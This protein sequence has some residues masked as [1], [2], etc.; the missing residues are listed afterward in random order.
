MGL[1]AANSAYSVGAPVGVPP[2]VP[3]VSIVLGSSGI[4]VSS[5]AASS[6]CVSRP[7]HP[8]NSIAGAKSRTEARHRE[9]SFFIVSPF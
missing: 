7:L 5:N 3:V 4:S 8:K 2:P 1:G 9:N 6:V